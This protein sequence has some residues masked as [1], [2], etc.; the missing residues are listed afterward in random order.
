M[1]F[2]YRFGLRTGEI[3]R[4]AVSD[5]ILNDGDMVVYIRNSFR[6]ET[7]SENGVRQLP[8]IG[9][10]SDCEHTL[11]RRWLLHVDT[12]SEG[13]SLSTLLPQ[14]TGQRDLVDRSSCVRVVVELLRNA[15][16]D[17]QIRLRH[18]RHTC[19]TRL[20]LAMMVEEVSHGTVGDIYKAL[21]GDV[22]PAYVRRILV[23]DSR[24][25]RRGL[26]ATAL[27]MGHA[28]PD[29]THRHYI[30]LADIL[31]KEWTSKVPFT[32]DGKAFS[33]AYQTTYANVRQVRSRIGE[34]ASL[35]A[36]SEHFAR[37]S[38][39]PCPTLCA[40]AQPDNEARLPQGLQS[41]PSPADVDRLLSLATLRDS[42]D[43]L[44]DRFLTT[45]NVVASALLSASIL[46]ERTGYTDFSVPQAKSD[47]YW[48]PNSAE[49]YKSLEKESKRVRSFLEIIGNS[50]LG[51]P[52]LAAISQ[53]WLD[54]YHPHLKYLLIN[55]RSDLAQLLAALKTL[56]IPAKDL[57]A[58]IP[59]VKTVDERAIW[60]SV[61]Q[62]LLLQGLSVCRKKRMPSG[63]SKYSPDNRIGLMLR[64]S[65]SHQLGYQRTLNRALFVVSVWL[66]LSGAYMP[67]R[68]ITRANE[69]YTI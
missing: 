19:A 60:A 21:W 7:K 69:A 46:Q 31:L 41:L 3:A 47:D 54:A 27:F 45:V 62:W 56:G 22:A 38:G 30:H 65:E 18:L 37:Q 25:T 40:V 44:A 8:L 43:G 51:T 63:S 10:L 12:F 50:P 39:I 35:A 57:E 2:A 34:E 48:L 58:L 4:L 1:F 61:E 24:I 9:S 15:T 64:A 32:I 67:L 53:I 26:Y 13:D 5:V 55:K 16:G 59:D 11:I 20:H 14:V 49:R 52:H 17:D 23:G 28:S 42:I 33:Y 6:G 68:A 66:Q 29:V 36:F